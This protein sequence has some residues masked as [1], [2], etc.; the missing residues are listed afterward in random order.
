[1]LERTPGPLPASV[2]SG[3]ASGVSQAVPNPHR[4]AK[5]AESPSLPASS[6]VTHFGGKAGDDIGDN[7]IVDGHKVFYQQHPLPR[8]QVIRCGRWDRHSV[9][10]L[11]ALRFRP[12]D[13][14]EVA[15]LA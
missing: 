11:S 4:I 8:L 3:E 15:R 9:M 1:M 13:L 10:V 14:P 6:F 5:K 7:R 2:S 12:R